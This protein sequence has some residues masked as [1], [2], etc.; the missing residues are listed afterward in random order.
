MKLY[1]SLVIVFIA[2]V[3]PAT[4]RVFN[5]CSLARALFALGVPK[6]ELPIWTCIAKYESS[7]RTD[8]IGAANT[9]GS[10]DYGIFQ[11]NDRYWCQPAS[12][13]GSSNGCKIS[14]N[15][16]LSDNLQPTVNCVRK[17]KGERK[18]WAAWTTWS[19][20]SGALPTINNC[21]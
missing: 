14:C 10:H 4:G 13:R 18:G 9:N 5:R 3:V 17:I 21:F 16:L 7:F 19:K 15:A 2:L 6:A 11:I 12:G 8:A 20:C 1:I